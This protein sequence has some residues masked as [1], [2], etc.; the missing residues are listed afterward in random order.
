MN[1]EF[2]ILGQEEG[3]R[4]GS[5]VGQW[6]SGS[7]GQWVGESVGWGRWADGKKC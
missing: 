4:Q 1:F 2:W 6:V 7:V 3:G 5:G